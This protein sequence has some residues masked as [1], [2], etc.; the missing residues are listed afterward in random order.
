[1]SNLKILVVEDEVIIR[2]DIIMNLRQ[3][4]C[5]VVGETGYAEKA[6]DLAD[7]LEPDLILMDIRLQGAMSGLE[8]AKVI[9]TKH[10]IPIVIMSAYSFE[11]S[12]IREEIPQLVSF[13]A[14]PVWPG[15][16]RQ[17][18]EAA[19]LMRPEI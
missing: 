5:E 13:L 17:V 4:G 2:K 1:M 9:G 8:A 12:A 11:E 15:M 6:I 7:L 16:I 3:I 14:K 19:R 18:V 10:R